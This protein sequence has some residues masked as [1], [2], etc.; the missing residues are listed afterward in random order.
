[1]NAKQ[2]LFKK[3]QEIQQLQAKERQL[4]EKEKAAWK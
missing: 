3:D 1:L 2:K 4:F